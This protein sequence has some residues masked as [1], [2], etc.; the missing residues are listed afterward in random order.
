[1][2]TAT[3]TRKDVKE[4]TFVWEGVDRNN[5]QIRGESQ[6]RV[7]DRRHDQPAPPGHPHQKIKK[8][9]RSAAARRSASRTSRSSR[10]SSR[11]C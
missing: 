1:M 6:G 5:R 11:R 10:A 4:Y 8:Q 3:A 9:S 7:A 2:A